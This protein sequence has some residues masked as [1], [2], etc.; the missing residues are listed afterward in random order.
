MENNR[1]T[2][3]IWTNQDQGAGFLQIG[4]NKLVYSFPVF[5]LEGAQLDNTI[6]SVLEGRS[7]Y[8]VMPLPM[9]WEQ[10]RPHWDHMEIESTAS[11]R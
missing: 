9:D 1:V 5:M 2:F 4:D 6:M 11:I 8:G 3:N 10:M 7:D